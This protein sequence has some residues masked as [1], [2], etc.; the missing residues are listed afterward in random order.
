[1]QS[2]SQGNQHILSTQST[3]NID[4]ES[5]NLSANHLAYVI[6]TSG[7]TGQPKGV[8]VEHQSLCNVIVDNS[9]RFN[10]ESDSKFLQSTSINFDAATWV[11]CMSLV[12][13]AA[14][15]VQKT[16]FMSEEEI[17]GIVT[18]Q[19]VTHLMMTPSTLGTL[20]PAQFTSVRNVIAGGEACSQELAAKWSE[21]VAFFNAY[22]PTEASIC[23][24]IEQ[25]SQH[26]AIS[27]GKPNSNTKVYVLNTHQELAPLGA[28]G[29]L[30]LGGDCLARGYLNNDALTNEKFIPNPFTTEPQSRLY[31]TGDLVR[32]LP[33]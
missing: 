12:K 3:E 25:V 26:K 31:K 7:S 5:L 2:D 23:V 32:W 1:R 14:V 11:I 20:E 16:P 22:G 18:E 29:E 21:Q 28:I 33:D 30:Y 6:Y 9:A 17:A 10:I 15:L 19:G 4:K 8:M 24:T 27:L 13:G